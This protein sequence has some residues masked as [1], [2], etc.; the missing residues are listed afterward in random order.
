MFPNSTKQNLLTGQPFDELSLHT[1]FPG[2][3]GSNEMTGGSP[4]YQRGAAATA[5][6]GTQ[7]V[8]SAPVSMSL[9]A[10]TVKWIGTWNGGA[11]VGAM[12][13][14]GFT[15]KNFVAYGDLIHCPSHGYPADQTVT[16]FDGTPP[17]GITEGATLYV[18][19]PT[20]N[21]FQLAETAGG[22]PLTLTSASSFGC[23]VSGITEEVYPVQGV[24]RIDSAV[25]AIPD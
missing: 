12:P 1:G 8:L 5:I 16:L 9:P 3:I 15:P 17:G 22:T 14:G 13:N 2:S 20:L 10:A 4:P 19:N 25:F 23:V 11:F 21:T 7:R 6:V 24:H 18:V